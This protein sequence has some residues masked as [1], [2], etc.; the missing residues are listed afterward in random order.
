MSP[1]QARERAEASK[2]VRRAR[3]QIKREIAAGRLDLEAALR[4]PYVDGMRAW[5][6]LIAQP[7]VGRAKVGRA[8]RRLGDLVPHQVQVGDLTEEQ[9]AALVEMFPGS[10]G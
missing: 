5:D 8:F 9:L 3:A 1:E 7:W 10:P 2:I 4:R 6:L